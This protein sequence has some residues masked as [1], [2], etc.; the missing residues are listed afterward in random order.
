MQGLKQAVSAVAILVNAAPT[1]HRRNYGEIDPS[2]ECRWVSPPML[3]SAVGKTALRQSRCL[4]NDP[5]VSIPDLEWLGSVRIAWIISNQ[6][7]KNTLK[8]LGQIASKANKKSRVVLT[9]LCWADSQWIPDKFWTVLRRQFHEQFTFIAAV[10]E[11]HWSCSVTAA[12]PRQGPKSCEQQ[13]ICE[14][15]S[16]TALW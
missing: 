12:S 8:Q 3:L 4:S 2:L 9:I 7:M 14:Q 5:H 6:D 11:R 13:R 15:H 16:T 1:W 10:T